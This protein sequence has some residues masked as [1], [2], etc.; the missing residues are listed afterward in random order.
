MVS[1]A[2]R[3]STLLGF[4][5]SAIRAILL[6]AITHWFWPVI[7]FAALAGICV[8]PRVF[9]GKAEARA[10]DEAPATAGS[11][12]NDPE[13]RTTRA[14]DVLDIGTDA[15]RIQRA[16]NEARLAGTAGYDEHGKRADSA[17]FKKL[18]EEQGPDGR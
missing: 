6:G 5:A 2:H 10:I 16:Y 13:H 1:I 4:L 15:F 8:F 18:A 3:Y 11:F 14:L 12:L 9:Y 17:A 7:L